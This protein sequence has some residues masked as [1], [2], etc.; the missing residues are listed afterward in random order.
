[1]STKNPV[2]VQRPGRLLLLVGAGLVLGCILALWL[3]TSSN[4]P[5]A[6]SGLPTQEIIMSGAGDGV[7]V[8]PELG[9]ITD[10]NLVVIAVE[11]GS[12]AEKVGI[13]RG[14]ILKQVNKTV[15]AS[16]SPQ[17]AMN[18]IRGLIVQKSNQPLDLTLMR[19]GQ[20]QK[21]QVIPAPPV[22]H[23]GQPTPTP[24][25]TNYGYF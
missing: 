2:E 1:M 9:I 3:F 25:P 12:A 21:F 4:P 7:E 10:P 8:A 6:Q 17:F 16:M 11:Q 18:T 5:N 13:Q 23:P 20:E 15:L 24:L 19:G 14:D 22:P